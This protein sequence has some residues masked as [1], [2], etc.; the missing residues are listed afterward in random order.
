MHIEIITKPITRAQA[1]EI[2]KEFY[3]EMI[4]GVVDIEQELIALGGE[5]HMEANNALMAQGSS[6]QGAVWGF[7]IYPKRTDAD[8]IEYTALINIR[9]AAHNRTMTVEREA[10]RMKMKKII[11]KL[12]V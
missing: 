3:Q 7:N 6:S 8:W 1:L 4:K 5:Y 2:G 12:I 9:P 11:E 10:I